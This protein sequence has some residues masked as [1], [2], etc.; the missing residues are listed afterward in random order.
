M[1]R[2]AVGFVL[3]SGL[4]FVQIEAVR[5]RCVVDVSLCDRHKL[6]HCFRVTVALAARRG[7]ADV[8]IAGLS[9]GC[10]ALSEEVKLD[11]EASIMRWPTW[12]CAGHVLLQKSHQQQESSLAKALISWLQPFP[13]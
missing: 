13:P 3:C 8:C 1:L 7:L 2:E 6:G 12:C 9:P 5:P 11:R 10:V 4:S